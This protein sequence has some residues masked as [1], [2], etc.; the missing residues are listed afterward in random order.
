MF[1][2]LHDTLKR[3]FIIIETETTKCNNLFKWN[4]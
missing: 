2:F 3:D 1:V 4:S